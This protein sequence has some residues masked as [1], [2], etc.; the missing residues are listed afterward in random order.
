MKHRKTAAI[1]AFLLTLFVTG[2]L[3]YQKNQV[4][5]NGISA[6]MPIFPIP[7]P[8]ENQRILSIAYRSPVPS[9]QILSESGMIVISLDRATRAVKFERL[10][11]KGSPLGI[12]EFLLAYRVKRAE[13]LTSHNVNALIS[14]ADDDFF[15]P[16]DEDAK[17]YINAVYALL[18]IGSN[19]RAYLV[20][21]ADK[22]FRL[23]GAKP[24][25]F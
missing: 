13:G 21:L 3:Y 2:A 12:G 20:G 11:E 19:G 16:P 10:Y 23:L 15:V 14:F 5:K 9:T 7:H 25:D 17:S 24:L 22:D 18:R 4:I 8:K 6:F 1:I